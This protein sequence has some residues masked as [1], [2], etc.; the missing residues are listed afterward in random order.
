MGLQDARAVA[1]LNK[2]P[3][4]LAGNW[5]WITAPTQLRAVSTIGTQAPLLDT[6]LKGALSNFSI[7]L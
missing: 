3:P 6:R 5:A 7:T 2:N 1:K 4:W